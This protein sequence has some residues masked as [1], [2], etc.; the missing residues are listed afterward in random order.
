MR[1]VEGAPVHAV[2]GMAGMNL[3]THFGDAPPWVAVRDLNH[4]GFTRITTTESELLFEYVLNDT[5]DVF[6]SVVIPRKSVE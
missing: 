1:C 2:V 5:G 6:D 4:Y 3:S